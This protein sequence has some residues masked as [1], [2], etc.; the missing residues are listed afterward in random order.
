MYS[1]ESDRPLSSLHGGSLAS[2]AFWFWLKT[3]FKLGGNIENEF[4]GMKDYHQMRLERDD[5]SELI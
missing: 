5:L 4:D 3:L 1:C 2:A